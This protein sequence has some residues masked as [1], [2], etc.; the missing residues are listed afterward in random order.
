MHIVLF[1]QSTYMYTDPNAYSLVHTINLH[2]YT[3]L[4]I[5][6]FTQS[7]YMYTDPNA[8]S[9]VHTVNLHVY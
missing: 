7:T 6:L 2:I 4:R 3:D 5:V 9:L 1:T 8:Y